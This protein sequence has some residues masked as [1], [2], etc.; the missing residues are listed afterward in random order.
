MI[1]WFFVI[2]LMIYSIDIP[3]I[4]EHILAQIPS[5]ELGIIFIIEKWSRSW[6]KNVS[7]AAAHR[8]FSGT[9]KITVP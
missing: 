6:E 7:I 8:S 9:S 2:K 5:N 3:L 4:F 1:K